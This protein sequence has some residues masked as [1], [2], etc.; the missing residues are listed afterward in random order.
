MSKNQLEEQ[1]RKNAETVFSQGKEPPAGHRERFEQRLKE[2]E[3][4]QEA[5]ND[6]PFIVA[7]ARSP[8]YKMAVGK[9]WLIA[10]ITAAVLAG[11][12][13]LLNPFSN[14]YQCSELIEV[15][16]YYCMLLEEEADVTR[17]LIQNVDETYRETLFANVELIEN[18]MI[19]D[20]QVTNDDYIKIIVSFYTNKIEILQNLQNVIIETSK[21]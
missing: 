10:T 4:R 6:Y 15:R 9:K 16:N 20:I 18:D 19:P 3:G 7:S 8:K 11:F 17:Q 13:F 12:M 21:E 1:I 2:L 14:E 5:G